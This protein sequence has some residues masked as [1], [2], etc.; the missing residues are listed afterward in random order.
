[1]GW[2]GGS[3]N[4]VQFSVQ[5][6]EIILPNKWIIERTVQGINKKKCSALLLVTDL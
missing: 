3:P 1:M 5:G 4:S 2:V 6:L